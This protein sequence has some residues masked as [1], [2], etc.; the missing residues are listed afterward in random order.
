MRTRA[1]QPNRPYAR[2][3][4]ERDAERATGGGGPGRRVDATGPRSR[5]NTASA[6]GS[7]PKVQQIAIPM[8]SGT[9]GPASAPG[10]S[11]ALSRRFR[12]LVRRALLRR[13]VV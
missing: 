13:P 7:P 11:A 2:F 4:L 10:R 8:Q 3:A 5:D 12:L 9:A 6:S 1:D